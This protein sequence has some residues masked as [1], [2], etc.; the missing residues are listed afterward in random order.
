[1]SK[2]HHTLNEAG[3]FKPPRLRSAMTS[4]AEERSY[5][6]P[7]TGME[8]P[9]GQSMGRAAG[10][11]GRKKKDEQGSLP[12]ARGASA[13]QR[14][15]CDHL[16][17]LDEISICDRHTSNVTRLKRPGRNGPCGISPMLRGRQRNHGLQQFRTGCRRYAEVVLSWFKSYFIWLMFVRTSIIHRNNAHESAPG[18]I[19]M[20]MCQTTEKTIKPRRLSGLGQGQPIHQNEKNRMKRKYPPL[21]QPPSGC[22]LAV[23]TARGGGYTCNMCVQPFPVYGRIKRQ[24]KTRLGMLLGRRP[25]GLPARRQRLR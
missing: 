15:R 17:T 4:I 12:R 11:A 1:M 6:K 5:W 18:Y 23:R 10:H 19:N 20:C 8:K 21:V 2:V 25:S 7:G 24:K 16:P 22:R 14:F 3:R 9:K 13:R